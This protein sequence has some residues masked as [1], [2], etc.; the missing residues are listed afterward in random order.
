M[1]CF[2]SSSIRLVKALK[3][4]PKGKYHGNRC[5]CLPGGPY[6]ETDE[7]MVTLI[8]ELNII[9]VQLFSSVSGKLMGSFTGNFSPIVWSELSTQERG[10]L[11]AQKMGK[12]LINKQGH[13]MS[14]L[15][16]KHLKNISRLLVMYKDC[17]KRY[18]YHPGEFDLFGYLSW[19]LKCPEII[20]NDI[21][22]SEIA[23]WTLPSNFFQPNHF[24]IRNCWVTFLSAKNWKNHTPSENVRN[25]FS[26]VAN[27]LGDILVKKSVAVWQR[28]T[29]ILRTVWLSRTQISTKIIIGYPWRR[30]K[31]Y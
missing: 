27:L 2:S 31:K 17:L 4:W 20:G 26:L 11:Q 18:F 28:R 9:F 5:S 12:R 22:I 19:E 14:K 7:E 13:P 29:E 6:K 15:S 21:F 3:T 16:Q 23:S 25:Y 8:H 1:L 24:L 30:I 10:F